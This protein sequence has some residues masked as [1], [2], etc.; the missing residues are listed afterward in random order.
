MLH[1]LLRMRPDI[2]HLPFA[3]FVSLEDL[4]FIRLRLLV[5][6]WDRV[7]SAVALP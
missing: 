6:L 7:G 5:S 4:L 1:I 3:V 2:R